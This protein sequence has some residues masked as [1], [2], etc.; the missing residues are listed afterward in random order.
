MPQG[1]PL[2]PLL[3]NIVL[4]DLDMELERRGHRFVRY[5][6]DFLVLVRSE[7]A[8]R[9]VMESI[10]RFLE[11]KANGGWVSAWLDCHLIISTS[12]EIPNPISPKAAMTI[13]MH[14]AAITFS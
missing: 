12:F 5:A 2:S 3:A 8:G 6:D 1:G 7:S 10:S 4:H 11:P 14:P 9:R 13:V